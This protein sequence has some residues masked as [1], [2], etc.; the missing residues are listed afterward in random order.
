MNDTQPD[1]PL[2]ADQAPVAVPAPAI[3]VTPTKAKPY[4]AIA[5][6][7]A[8]FAGVLALVMRP[9]DHPTPP[10]PP[11]ASAVA[12]ESDLQGL[13]N[14][15]ISLERTF[16]K[17]KEP[18]TRAK[19]TEVRARITTIVEGMKEEDVPAVARRFRHAR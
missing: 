17:T 10:T 18:E 1:L 12:P 2:T 5:M 3:P 8:A 9:V 13:I 14:Q 6:T 4:M 19:A 16:S 11:V 7:L 15:Y